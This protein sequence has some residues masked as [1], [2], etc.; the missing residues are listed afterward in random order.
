MRGGVWD[1]LVHD[2][3][4]GVICTSVFELGLWQAR[5]RG[6]S[7]WFRRLQHR[8]VLGFVVRSSDFV[9]ATKGPMS[10]TALTQQSPIVMKMGKA[11]LEPGEL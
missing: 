4:L 10:Q 2:L 3:L 5:L 7:S 11:W 6:G 8:D 1:F 9:C